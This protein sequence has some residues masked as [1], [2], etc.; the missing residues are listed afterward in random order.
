MSIFRTFGFSFMTDTVETRV[1]VSRHDILMQR[2]S[3][4]TSKAEQLYATHGHNILYNR[5]IKDHARADDKCYLTNA[6]SSTNSIIFQ[7]RDGIK[8]GSS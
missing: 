8:T 6:F 1:A 3:K 7:R 4:G 5:S 2:M